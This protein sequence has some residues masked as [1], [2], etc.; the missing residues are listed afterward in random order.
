MR[1]GRD[2][3]RKGSDGE[4]AR[5]RRFLGQWTWVSV[6]EGTVLST[7]FFGRLWGVG[8]WGCVFLSAL[9]FSPQL[10]GSAAGAGHGAG[11]GADPEVSNLEVRVD[12]LEQRTNSSR[13]DIL[14]K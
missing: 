5:G 9:P 8:A 3:S 2:F 14:P 12:P 13:E 1:L 7:E 10:S 4:H 11:H 6:R